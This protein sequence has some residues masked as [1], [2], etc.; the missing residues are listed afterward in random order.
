MPALW[1][2][3][4]IVL[5]SCTWLCTRPAWRWELAYPLWGARK[6]TEL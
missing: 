6:A 2:A 5:N 1:S 4:T 3:L